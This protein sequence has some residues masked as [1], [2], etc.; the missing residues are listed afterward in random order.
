[1]TAARNSCEGSGTPCGVHGVIGLSV[2]WTGPSLPVSGKVESLEA[3]LSLEDEG[4]V[5]G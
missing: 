4:H 1:M 2:P 3:A 5:E